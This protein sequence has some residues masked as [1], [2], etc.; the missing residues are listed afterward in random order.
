MLPT[1]HPDGGSCVFVVQR[2][3]AVSF[4]PND[5][6][7]PG[8]GRALREAAAGGVMVR[9]FACRVDLQEISLSR[10]IPICLPPAPLPR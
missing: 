5:L 2:D 10:E 9:A 8:F 3:D 7:D 6:A 1:I 4:S